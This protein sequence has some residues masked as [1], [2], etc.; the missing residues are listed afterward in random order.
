[1][2]ATDIAEDIFESIYV[3]DSKSLSVMKFKYISLR[4][5]TYEFTIAESV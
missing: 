5:S 4:K 2:V 1:M 3:Y